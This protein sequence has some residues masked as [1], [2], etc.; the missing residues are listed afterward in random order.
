MIAEF[1]I[2]NYRSFKEKQT[3]SLI[4]TKDNELS[5]SNVFKCE[6]NL[7]LLKSAVIFGPNAS[8]KTNFFLA[9]NF[10]LYFS[11]RS[12]PNLQVDEPT[13]T[14]AFA[15]SKQSENSPSSFE[16]IFFLPTE[17]NEKK[18][19]YRYGFSLTNERIVDEYLF[20]VY[21]AREVNLF[22]RKGQEILNTSYFK[23]GNR[24]KPFV[25]NNSSFLSVCAQNNGEISGAIVKFFMNIVVSSGLF[26][27]ISITGK[28]LNNAENYKTILEFL[29]N[30][31][32]QITGIQSKIMNFKS[33]NN[34]A[35]EVQAFLD[36][37]KKNDP[38]F[39]ERE[40]IYLGHRM[41]D[42]NE[43]IGEKFI[44]LDDESDGTRKLFN[45]S[46]SILYALKN[47]TPVFIDEFDTSLHPLILRKILKMF[48]SIKYNIN[49][50]Q[51][52]ISCHA[53]HIM[54]KDLLRRDQI[55]FCKKDNYGASDLYSLANYKESVRK[56]A[57]YNKNYLAGNY[58]AIPYID[59]IL[60]QEGDELL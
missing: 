27:E 23:E 29:Q 9:L 37:I 21:I 47:G 4:S 45:Y 53:V 55:W 12:G 28:N 49:N 15:F 3:F 14:E 39:E 24:S 18:I 42:N 8:G 40:T 32:I 57:A 38:D 54:T 34:E 48:N 56:D 20:A 19:K 5:K 17:D 43:E 44:S 60:E 10:F 11:I 58:G 1:T 2:E 51:L 59:E 6:K 46:L 30:A 16:L 22:N 50:A 13:G 52:V 25:R 36:Y 7:Q 31:D 35:P 41:F 26:N 33:R